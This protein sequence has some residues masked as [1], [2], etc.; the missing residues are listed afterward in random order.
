MILFLKAVHLVD[1]SDTRF[2]GR[3]HFAEVYNNWKWDNVELLTGVIIASTTP[4]RILF[5]YFRAFAPP[6][7]I[8][9][10]KMSQ[11]AP[12]ASVILKNDEDYQ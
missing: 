12:Y 3:T 10:A 4:I 5:I 11:I 6:P 7:S 2:I 1:Y 8:L 9:E